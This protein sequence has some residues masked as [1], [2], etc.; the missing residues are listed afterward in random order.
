MQLERLEDP[1]SST[2]L[3]S[4]LVCTSSHT[5]AIL[6]FDGL[7]V[8]TNRL[9]P[10]AVAAQQAVRGPIALH[11]C[12]DCGHIYNAAYDDSLVNYEIDY[13]NSQMFSPRFR[14]YATSLAQEL[15]ANYAL[16]GKQVIEIGGGRGEFLGILC[17]E[18]G[19]SGVSFGPSYAPAVGDVL[20]ANVTFVTDYFTEAYAEV[21]A[22]LIVCRHVLEHFERPRVLLDS[23]RAAIGS[24]TDL[25]VYLEVPNGEE[26]V[27]SALLS[28][29]HYQHPSYFTRAS[30]GRLCQECGFEVLTFREQFDRQFLA[31]E[32]KPV[33]NLGCSATATSKIEE[34][35]VAGVNSFAAAHKMQQARWEGVF[36]RLAGRRTLLWGAGAKAVTFLNTFCTIRSSV[37]AVVD[38]NPRK[39]GWYLPGSGHEIIS[40]AAAIARAPECIIVANRIYLD[41]IK[42]NDG[43]GSNAY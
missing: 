24:R 1:S 3:T 27:E 6:R 26:I 4:C 18:S 13:E 12:T 11:F 8:D 40:P 36:E 21:T 25:T 43:V 38:V 14:K 35:L 19:C 16:T 32:A 42:I 41:E 29:I 39:V 7:P 30:L 5:E 34:S 22:E 23:V 37:E 9:W 33:R 20:P 31:I 15:A 17:E 2:S 28:E 10:S